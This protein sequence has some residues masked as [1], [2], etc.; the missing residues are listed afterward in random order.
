[1]KTK[2]KLVGFDYQDAGTIE[3]IGR[4]LSVLVSTPAGTCA[5]DRSYGIDF[6][7]VGMPARAAENLLAM[8][9]AEKIPLYEPRADIISVTCTVNLAGELTAV[10]RIGPNADYYSSEE[11]PAGGGY[12]EGSEDED[13]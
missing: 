7:I 5:G 8:E 4:N 9:L 11:E 2:V 12:F 3:E 13:Y 6:S 1:M 10:I